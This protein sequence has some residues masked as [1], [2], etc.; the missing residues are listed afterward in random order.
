MS[1]GGDTHGAERLRATPALCVTDVFAPV[2]RRE[3]RAK[4]D[5]H[6]RGPMPDRR[7]EPVRARASRLPDGDEQDLQQF[8]NK[9]PAGLA[10]GAVAHR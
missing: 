4:G 2:P 8:V 3:Q 5:C 10:A 9:S 1:R 7:R 6:L